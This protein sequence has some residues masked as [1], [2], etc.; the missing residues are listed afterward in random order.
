MEM[1]KAKENEILTQAKA[2][3]AGT[4]TGY[5]SA[6]EQIATLFGSSEPDL[7]VGWI[8]SCQPRHLVTAALRVLCNL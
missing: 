1:K 2:S 5:K 3:A 6:A 8:M 7:M 4:P